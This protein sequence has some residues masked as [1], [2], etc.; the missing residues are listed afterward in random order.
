MKKW[1]LWLFA[2]LFAAV[3]TLAACGDDDDDDVTPP[4][5]SGASVGDLEGT[6]K[7][8]FSEGTYVFKGDKLTI[9]EYGQRYDG[10]F[11]LKNDEI[12]FTHTTQGQQVTEKGK[13]ILLYGKQV[14]VIKSTYENGAGNYDETAEVL[15]KNGVAPKTLVSDIQGK[16]FWY[17]NGNKDEVRAAMIIKDNNFEMIIGAWGQKYTG[18]FTY[19]GGV[20]KLNITNGFTSR[21]P[22]TGYGSGYGNLNPATLEGTWYELYK[23]HWTMEDGMQTIFIAATTEAYGTIAGLP[24][25]FYK[26]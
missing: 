8:P 17:M 19:T 13:V 14:L 25:V 12:T 9:D 11:T 20:M 22:G 21:E 26:Q 24:A 2:S 4:S 15:F 3:F 5:G 6:W 10:T 18:T 1:N 7:S 23:E 16:W